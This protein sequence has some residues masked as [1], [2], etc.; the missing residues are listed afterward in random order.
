[1][2]NSHCIHHFWGTLF[3]SVRTHLTINQIKTMHNALA[4]GAGVVKNVQIH[5]QYLVQYSLK[6]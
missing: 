5:S 2:L 1:M 6:V 3:A 4:F